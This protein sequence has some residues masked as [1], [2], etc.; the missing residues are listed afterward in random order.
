MKSGIYRNLVASLADAFEQAFGGNLLCVVQIG[1][2]AHGGFS[3]QYSDIDVAFVL[4]KPGDDAEVTELIERLKSSG[5]EGAERLSIFYTTPDFSWGRLRPIDQVDL[6]D[7]GVAI[8]GR[9]P[10]LP[11]PSQA[12]ATKASWH[13]DVP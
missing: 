6:I 1:S 3:E 7:G 5:R 9:I 13:R 2:L 8:R 11:R 10:E 4:E 12:S